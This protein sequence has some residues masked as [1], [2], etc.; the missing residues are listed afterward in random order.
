MGSGSL[1][2]MNWVQTV[3][4]LFG[5]LNFGLGAEAM[6]SKGSAVSLMAGGAIGILAI[7]GAVVS[8][9]NS[10][11]GYGLAALAC[12]AILGRFG[13]KFIKDQVFFPGGLLV[14]AAVVTLI[15][16]VAGHFMNRGASAS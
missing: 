13:P 16:L 10:L 9:N 12:V 4:V 7:V 2:S 6:I 3:V 11:I 8:R 1:S 15:C 5:L 14:S